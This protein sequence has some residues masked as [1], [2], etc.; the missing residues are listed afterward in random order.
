MI[1]FYYA[2]KVNKLVRTLLKLHKQILDKKL[3]KVI[4]IILTEVQSGRPNAG[5]NK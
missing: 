4:R 2:L 5:I 1:L 3:K